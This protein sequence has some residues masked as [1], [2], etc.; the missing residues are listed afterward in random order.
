MDLPDRSEGGAMNKTKSVLIY[1]IVI[2]TL[3][4]S[5]FACSDHVKIDC[6]TPGPNPV[7]ELSAMKCHITT[8]GTPRIDKTKD[9]CGGLVSEGRPWTY[10]FTP[11]E[12][13]GPG[14]CIAAVEVV[15]SPPKKNSDVVIINEVNKPPTW[16]PEPRDISISMGSV[17]DQVNGYATDPDH[18]AQTLS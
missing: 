11:S 12:E 10:D 8:N 6:S 3:V 7:D 4:F 15:E 5:S 16:S 13:D 9:T 18:P 14:S 17:Y 2:L 1:L